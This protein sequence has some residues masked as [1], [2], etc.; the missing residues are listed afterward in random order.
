MNW[1]LF[2]L[3]FIIVFLLPQGVVGPHFNGGT[4]TWRPLDTNTNTTPIQVLITQ[5]YMYT[6]S[7]V[8]CTIG[9]LLFYNF[10]LDCTSNCSTSGRYVPVSVSTYATGMSTS[11]NICYTQRSQV[12]NLTANSYFTICYTVPSKYTYRPLNTG[13]NITTGNATW[14]IS[15]TIDLRPRPNGLLNTPPTSNMMSP[16]GIPYN[17]PTLIQIPTADVDGAMAH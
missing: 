16:T 8:S 4:I 17:V 11:L 13:L 14:N 7:K 10:S 9:S 2:L 1:F 3:A 12:V 6:L 15:A 5:T